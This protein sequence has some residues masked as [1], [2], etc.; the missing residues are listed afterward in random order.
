[1]FENHEQVSKK[2]T[3]QKI[4]AAKQEVAYIELT[5]QRDTHIMSDYQRGLIITVCGVLFVTPD[6][7]FRST[8]RRAAHDDRLLAKRNFWGIN[9]DFL[10]FV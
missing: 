6:L 2:R 1:M 8:Y 10:A 7:A 9:H 5:Q 4:V 3:E